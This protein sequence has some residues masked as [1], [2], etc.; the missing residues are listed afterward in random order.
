[1]NLFKNKKGAVSEFFDILRAVLLVAGATFLFTSST[2]F[3]QD[4]DK[5]AAALAELTLEKNDQALAWLRLP[6]DQ[7]GSSAA[8]TNKEIKALYDYAVQQEMTIGDI[9][10]LAHNSVSLVNL[11]ILAKSRG[12]DL[13]LEKLMNT[14]KSRQSG[15]IIQD[16]FL[17]NLHGDIPKDLLINPFLR[18]MF[19][20]IPS[21]T[22]K[23]ESDQEKAF[24]RECKGKNVREFTI[25]LPNT[26]RKNSETIPLNFQFCEDIKNV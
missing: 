21:V 15:D 16:W 24:V 26:L 17:T 3:Q 7:F 23:S 5:K 4:A 25:L 22:I 12:Y 20:Q 2:T 1:M 18:N 19:V 11:G 10:V 14:D 8:L 13:I 9:I 6:I